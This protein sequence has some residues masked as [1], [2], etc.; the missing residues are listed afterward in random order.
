MKI[1]PL[2]YSSIPRTFDIAKAEKGG[3]EEISSDIFRENYV[4]P[5]GVGGGAPK[6]TLRFCKVFSIIFIIETKAEKGEVQGHVKCSRDL[7]VKFE[8]FACVSILSER[9]FI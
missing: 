9:V 4:G 5:G 3:S 7:T 1:I 6:K 2:L 8:I